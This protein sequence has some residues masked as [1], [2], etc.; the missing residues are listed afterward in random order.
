MNCTRSM[1]TFLFTVKQS[2]HSPQTGFPNATVPWM[3]PGN[4]HGV[5]PWKKG[6]GAEWGSSSS[7]PSCA[8]ANT[9]AQFSRYFT[10]LNAQ[11]DR[12]QGLCS[13]KQP[14]GSDSM[15]YGAQGLGL[16]FHGS[17]TPL[18]GNS[19]IFSE[20]KAV[21][22]IDQGIHSAQLALALSVG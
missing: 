6:P 11:A 12:A 17:T 13:L 14:E 1:C 19:E 3:E 7:S 8:T 9:S 18:L 21:R 16:G 15:E 2:E 4:A 22:N 10:P 20:I 5:T